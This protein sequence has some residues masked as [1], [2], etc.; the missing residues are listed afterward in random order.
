MAQNRKHG[1]R[2]AETPKRNHQKMKN[3]GVLLLTGSLLVTVSSPALAG[4][5]TPNP[6]RTAAAS[7]SVMDSAE[8]FLSMT[9]RNL[10]ITADPNVKLSFD[11]A[12]VTTEA[13]P[14]TRL[15]QVLAESAVK[16]KEAAAYAASIIAKS[17]V[18]KAES[19]TGSASLNM[20]E[21]EKKEVITT[22]VTPS[23]LLSNPLKV[24]TPSSPFGIRVSPITGAVDEFHRGQDYSA[25]CGTDVM[26]A[27]GGTVIYSQWHPYGGGNRVE[28]DHG[29]GLITTYNHLSA[30]KVKVGQK[31]ERGEVIA[32]SGTTG[33][34]TG[35]HLHF[36]VEV[37]H[38]VVNPLPWL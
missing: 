4:D 11:T 34:S 35:C 28:I 31:V 25:A 30:S 2:R 18:E 6:Q 14:E 12:K 22:P 9:R 38:N 37:N 15:K 29:N 26:A 5:E 10:T 13:G 27:A 8:N 23:K 24:M 20:P 1:R 33:A 3:A 32:L 19:P 17:A 7:K 21:A 36:E 16:D